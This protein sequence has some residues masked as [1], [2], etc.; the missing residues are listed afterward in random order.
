M[1]THGDPTST[2]RR[3]FAFWDVPC[4][5][6]QSIAGAGPHVVQPSSNAE[7]LPL[8]LR[9][10]VTEAIG[11]AQHLRAVLRQAQPLSTPNATL[12]RCAIVPPSFFGSRHGS[13]DSA[14]LATANAGPWP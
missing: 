5:I 14:I 13:S 7:V 3:P 8:S 1:D 10:G 9:P 6:C 11:F 4:Q 2:L 12:N